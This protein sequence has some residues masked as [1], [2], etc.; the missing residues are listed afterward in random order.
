MR[1]ELQCAAN[2][3]LYIMEKLVKLQDEGDLKT[4]TL[5]TCTDIGRM[6]LGWNETVNELEQSTG[7]RESM[8]LIKDV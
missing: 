2:A 1:R 8:V 7:G 6:L 5:R 3:L 4:Y